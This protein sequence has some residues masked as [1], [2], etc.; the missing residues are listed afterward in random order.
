[1]QKE[2]PRCYSYIRFSSPEQIKGNSLSR[3]LELSEQYAKENGFQLDQSLTLKD[4]GLSAFSG[5][6]RKRGSLGHFINLIKN[7]KIPKSSIL[8]VESLDR[9]SREQVLDAFDQ[10]REIIKNGIKI[11]TLADKMEYSEE[12]L[13][14]NIGQ[15]MISL[16]IMSRA[17]EESLQKSKRLSA[18]WKSKRKNLDE[19]KLT[20]LCPAWLRY[21]DATGRFE[22]IQDRCRLVKRIFKLSLDGKGMAAIAKSL[23]E[24]QIPSWRSESGWRKSYIYKILRNRAVLGEFQPHSKQNGKREPVGD[25]IPDYFPL[26]ITE[27][28]FY[29][30]QDRLSLFVNKGGKNGTVRNLFGTLAKCHYCGSSMQFINKGKPPKGSQY[31]LCDKARRGLG[32]YNIQFR[33]DEFE[34]TV[35]RFLTEID[36]KE[37]LATDENEKE[38][39]IQIL[40]SE[41]IKCKEKLKKTDNQIENFATA[42]GD[43]TDKKLQDLLKSKLKTSIE[44]QDALKSELS[45]LEQKMVKVHDEKSHVLD[46]LKGLQS[47][48][49]FMSTAPQKDVIDLRLKLR[50]EIRAI[51]DKIVVYPASLKLT[52]DKIKLVTD[53]LIDNYLEQNPKPIGASIQE[54]KKFIAAELAKTQT[55]KILR[56]ITI[57][58]H[59]GNWRMI[60]P[61]IDGKNVLELSKLIEH[62][63]EVN[64]I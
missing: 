19:R 8:I 49:Q 16:T 1:M 26:V 12:T 14:A 60:G 53:L 29:Q 48:I 23:N 63:D 13:N 47:L 31:L 5:D 36:Y 54:R 45:S 11:V 39:Q 30:V 33:Y 41:I 28:T 46:Q 34:E 22:K 55:Q 4:L 44:K 17:Y 2:P 15:L 6:N 24:E 21:N 18:A 7:G 51:V 40:K 3:Q 43:E 32:C 61:E 27:A 38:D 62:L 10:F 25:P 57:Y 20:R 56:S 64:N 58:F 9:L 35:L 42:I 52:A 50:A 37:L 59:N